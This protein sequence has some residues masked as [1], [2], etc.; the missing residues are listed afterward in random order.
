MSG[1]VSAK[2]EIP[3]LVDSEDGGVI[4]AWEQGRSSSITIV[5]IAAGLMGIGA[6]MTFS[7][8]AT[9]DRPM[10]GWEFWKFPALRQMVFVGGGLLALLVMSR[11]PYGIWLAD[12]GLMAKLLLLTGLVLLGLVYVPG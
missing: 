9:V 12:D 10:L 11:V 3:H 2:I 5:A 4:G 6:V 1:S 7:A 8:G